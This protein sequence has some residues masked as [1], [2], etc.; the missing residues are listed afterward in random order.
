MGQVVRGAIALGAAA[1]LAAAVTLLSG[2]CADLSKLSAG[3][4]DAR[5]D[6]SGDAL[7][8]GE[9]SQGEPCTSEAGPS[10]VAAGTYCIDST[11]VSNTEYLAFVQ[12]LDSSTPPQPPECAFNTSVIPQAPDGGWPPPPSKVAQPVVWVDWCDAYAYCSWAGKRLCGRIGGGG[13]DPAAPTSLMDQWYFACTR[14]GQVSYPYGNQYDGT[15]CNGADYN[16]GS[17]MLIDVGS[18]PSCQGGFPGLRDMSGNVEEWEDA[19]F[20][21]AAAGCHNRGGA[22]DNTA[23]SLRCDGNSANPRSFV[24]NHTGF[25]CCSQ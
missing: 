12:A 10:M 23:V 22:A 25:R 5:G 13:G 20:A 18:L 4:G 15:A 3:A 24:S 21:D 6:G 8:A 14:G 19:C 7:D 17:G 16:G 2:A 11:E 1:F 9:A